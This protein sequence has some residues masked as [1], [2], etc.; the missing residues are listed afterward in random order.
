[1][2]SHL[3]EEPVIV[4]K[5][6]DLLDQ[7]RNELNRRLDEINT[8]LDDRATV[9]MLRALQSDLAAALTRIGVLE[10]A[11]DANAARQQ[12]VHAV[13]GL[14]LRFGG[15]LIATALGIAWL[16]VTVWPHG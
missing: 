14:V 1:M 11:A 9:G 5:V 2:G 6:R 8:K 12:G 16:V 3:P 10:D 13:L 15:W 4:V 7:L